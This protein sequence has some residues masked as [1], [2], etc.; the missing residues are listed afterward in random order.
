MVEIGPEAREKQL[1]ALLSRL[2]ADLENS[3]R[4][5]ENSRENAMAVEVYR[6]RVPLV[7]SA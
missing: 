5:V 3:R 4:L 6:K 1:A 7:I 2:Q